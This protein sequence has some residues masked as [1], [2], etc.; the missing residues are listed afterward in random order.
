MSTPTTEKAIHPSEW[1]KELGALAHANLG[2]LSTKMF[3]IHRQTVKVVAINQIEVGRLLLKAR[4]EFAGDN[5]FGKWRQANTP[6]GSRQTAHNLMQLAK[7]HESGRITDKLVASLPTSTLAELLSAPDTVLK[8][9]ESKV[10]EGEHVTAAEI[11][12]ERKAEAPEPKTK[13]APRPVDT[14][15]ADIDRANANVAKKGMPPEQY[16]ASI[17]E[18]DVHFV[19]NEFV[20]KRSDEKVSKA[21][22]QEWAMVLFGIPP[23]SDGIPRWQVFKAM[24]AVYLEDD[25]LKRWELDILN[26]AWTTL[27]K[28]YNK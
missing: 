4:A 8:Y 27:L 25:T 1:G 3:E 23:Y 5:E 16:F 21:M 15:V 13:R 12:E 2:N 6:I 17:V 20:E 10:E 22:T 19:V 24:N 18:M 11:R 28:M 14:R 26:Q 9:V 7:Q